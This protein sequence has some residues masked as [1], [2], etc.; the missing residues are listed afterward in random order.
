MYD[1]KFVFYR[2][3]FKDNQK[4]GKGVEKSYDGVYFF[5]G[6][7]EYDEKESGN[8]R[9]GKVTYEGGFLDNLYQGQGK[10]TN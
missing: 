3:D 2:G 4:H 10:L 6:K 5:D 9:Y 7:F 8:L 1:N